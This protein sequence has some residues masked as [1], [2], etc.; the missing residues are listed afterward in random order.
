M[1]G[2]FL[3]GITTNSALCPRIAVATGGT[4]VSCVLG[5]CLPCTGSPT[6]GEE[7][8]FSCC[9]CSPCFCSACFCKPW[10]CSGLIPEQYTLRYQLV[11]A[12]EGGGVWGEWDLMSCLGFNLAGFATCKASTLPIILFF[13]SLKSSSS[14]Y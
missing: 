2:L 5:N 4:W 8:F 12:G 9:F 10:Q 7:K 1:F 14:S 6:P 13:W 11:G 3:F